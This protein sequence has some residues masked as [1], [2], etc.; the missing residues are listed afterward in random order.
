LK[1]IARP[2]FS[3]ASERTR[4]FFVSGAG[5]NKDTDSVKGWRTWRF[6]FGEQRIGDN[7]QQE[8]QPPPCTCKQETLCT[9]CSITVIDEEELDA[10]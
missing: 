7:G 1:G 10:N 5:M 3:L 6:A 9:G 2:E 8:Q 4:G